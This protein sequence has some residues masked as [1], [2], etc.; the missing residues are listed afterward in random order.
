MSGAE[1]ELLISDVQ[2]ELVAAVEAQTRLAERRA[3]LLEELAEVEA[4][5][6]IAGKRREALAAQLERLSKNSCG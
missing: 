6:H 3:A 4:Q 5:Q 1:A 2:S